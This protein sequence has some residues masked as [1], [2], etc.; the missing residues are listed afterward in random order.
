M[1]QDLNLVPLSLIS[2]SLKTAIPVHVGFTEH[3]DLQA[4]KSTSY[5]SDAQGLRAFNSYLKAVL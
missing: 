5:S 1:R 3:N 2:G 4:F